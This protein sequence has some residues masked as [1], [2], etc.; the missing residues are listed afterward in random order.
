[1]WVI[2]AAGSLAAALYV[3]FLDN[4]NRFYQ[5]RFCYTQVDAGNAVMYIYLSAIL[6]SF[7]LGMMVD[8]FGGRVYFFVVTM[9]AFLVAHLIYLF[10]PNCQ[11]VQ[12]SGALA[13]SFF[14][15]L[16]YAMYSNC[17]VPLFPL[18]V[19]SS[20]MGTAIGLLATFENIAETIVPEL[21]SLIVHS[22]ESEQAGYRYSE[23][24]YCGLGVIGVLVAS[25]MFCFR[26]TCKRLNQP[27]CEERGEAE[28]SDIEVSS[29][30]SVKPDENKIEEP[31]MNGSL[32]ISN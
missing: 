7:P 30:L 6:T 18:M 16:G 26:K 27:D 31:L 23:L 28:S 3:P 13:G 5:K 9:A 12:V 24:F 25:L 4:A 20:I 19:K 2:I 8:K 21:S 10:L 29:Q 15:G 11:G 1:M 14:L 17:L 22:Q 32:G